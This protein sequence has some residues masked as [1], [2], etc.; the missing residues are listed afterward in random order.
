M[1]RSL[2]EFEDDPALA[3]WSFE[4]GGD[5]NIFV[6]PKPMSGDDLKQWYFDNSPFNNSEYD[7]VTQNRNFDNNRWD[8]LGGQWLYREVDP[9]EKNSWFTGN[10]PDVMEIGYRGRR[11]RSSSP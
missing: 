11:D 10:P 1:H 2:S 5:N 7:F 4:N 9:V 6:N 8:Y 3:R